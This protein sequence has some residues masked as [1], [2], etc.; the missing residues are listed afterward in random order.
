M[1]MTMMTP[2]AYKCGL[3]DILST[4]TCDLSTKVFKPTKVPL[5]PTGQVV[6]AIEQVLKVSHTYLLHFTS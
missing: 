6:W 4:P 3:N 1:Y 2:Y 5:D